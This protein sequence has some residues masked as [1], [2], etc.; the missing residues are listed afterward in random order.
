V[1]Q[2]G[3]S[4][5]SFAVQWGYRSKGEK[6]VKLV[7]SL[8]KILTGFLVLC[9]ALSVIVGGLLVVAGFAGSLAGL[10]VGIYFLGAGLTSFCFFGAIFVVMGVCDKYLNS[11]ADQYLWVIG[12]AAEARL[13]QQPLPVQRSVPVAEPFQPYEP[14]LSCT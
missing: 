8:V 6:S 3:N 14:V 7:A 10:L 11:R 1:I 12:K 2:R 5:R 13:N 4:S 9:S